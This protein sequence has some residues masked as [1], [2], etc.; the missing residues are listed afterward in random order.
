MAATPQAQANGTQSSV[1]DEISASAP[2]GITLPPRGVRD[3]VEKTAGYIFRNGPSFE[4]RIR[5]GATSNPRMSFI[6]EDDP[7]HPYYQWRFDEIKA[8]RVTAIAAGRENE[9]GVSSK[10]REARKEPEAP[11]EFK[12][13]ARMPNINAQDLE[14]VKLTALFAAK[15]GRSWMSQLAQREAG[16]Y[17]FDFLRPQHTLY[18]FFSRLVDQYTDLLT[19]ASVDEGRPQKKRMTELEANVNNRFRVLDRARKRAEWLKYQESQ[20]V[21][22][23][24]EAEKE[25]IVW[26]ETDWQNFAVVETVVFDERDENADL[27]APTPLNDLQSQSLEQKAAMRVDAGR[28]IEEAIPTFDDYD[29]FYGNDGQNNQ[30]PSLAQPVQQM[31][32][33]QHAYAPTP[34]QPNFQPFQD[35]ND[36]QTRLT[37]L[38]ADRDRARAAQQANATTQP[39]KIRQD[40]IPR[41]QQLRAQ[42]LPPNTS[43]CPNCA[44]PIPNADIANHMRIEMLDPQWRDQFAKNQQRSSTTNLSTADVATNLKRL[45]S[46]RGDVF[47]PV[48]GREVLGEEERERRRRKE[49]GA[50]DGVSGMPSQAALAGMGGVM[51]GG[52]E[53]VEGR[54]APAADVQEQI[55]QLHQKYRG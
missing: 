36:E 7:Y 49:L 12:F 43:L 18:Q 34:P 4:E 3:I 27:P 20:K 6:F 41:A 38:Q 16:N 50:Y 51:P 48:T 28:R 26:A 35:Q 17:Q 39:V 14:V 24:V 19:G 45:A 5:Q 21:A 13:S 22:Q 2:P 30:P 15:N 42:Q 46:Q 1:L 47:D 11:E 37:T 32:P 54:G 52:M 31:P 29:T 44:Q 8:G 55:R 40:Y 10:G 25:R 9:V 53:G 33:P 23:E